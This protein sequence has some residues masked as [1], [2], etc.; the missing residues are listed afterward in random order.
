[1]TT[2][3]AVSSRA[4]VSTSLSKE[5]KGSYREVIVWDLFKR[6]GLQFNIGKLKPHGIGVLPDGTVIAANHVGELI[7]LD[8]R[9]GTIV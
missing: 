4:I 5:K 2:L 6:Q 3:R 9:E 1:M 8:R 7:L